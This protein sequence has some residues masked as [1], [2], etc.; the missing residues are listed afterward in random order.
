MSVADIGDSAKAAVTK[1]DVPSRQLTLG[2]GTIVTDGYGATN[3]DGFPALLLTA[4]E[5]G[6]TTVD[7]AAAYGHGK[8]EELLGRWSRELGLSFSV[9]TKIGITPG[10]GAAGLGQGTKR[11][12]SPD[13]L[14]RQAEASLERL[15]MDRVDM[16]LLHHPDPTVPVQRSMEGMI[17]CR[18]AGLA[19][20][21]GFS[22]LD[23][24]DA[25]AL[26]EA[27]MADVIQYPWSLLDSRRSP[28]L[29]EAGRRGVER[30]VFGTLAFGILAGSVDRDTRFDDEDWRGIARSGRDP[31][32]TGA[33]L[34]LGDRFEAALGNSAAF[35]ERTEQDRSGFAAATVAASLAV[36]P[37]EHVIVGCRSADELNN[38]DRGRH[39]TLP[40]DALDIARNMAVI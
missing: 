21:V 27:G 14:R 13:A 19:T 10:K 11:E 23:D 15:Q 40:E 2:L 18:D 26:I 1:K 4:A 3:P 25:L 32:T 31:G 22:N 6:I 30:M 28:V 38:L 17:A 12:G 33:P 39:L 24:G 34:F 9:C 8:S 36:A 7:T 5:A 29:H 20:R 35:L 16:L 37:A